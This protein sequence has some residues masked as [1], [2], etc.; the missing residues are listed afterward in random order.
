MY[1]VCVRSDLI[2]ANLL[3]TLHFSPMKMKPYSNCVF[4]VVCCCCCCCCF[5][6][7]LLLFFVCLLLLLFFVYLHTRYP[8]FAFL[9]LNYP[10]YQVDKWTLSH[11]G[12]IDQI[13]QVIQV[14]STK[15][16]Y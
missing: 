4:V 7:V 3:E 9:P 5:C 1:I 15:S 12:N 11:F 2:F 6:F 10:H 8:P 14:D 13:F 16:R